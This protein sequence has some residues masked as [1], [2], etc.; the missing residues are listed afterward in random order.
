M[1]YFVSTHYYM[2]LRLQN[3][4]V[5]SA[6]ST[7]PYYLNYHTRTISMAKCHAG[8]TFMMRK[9]IDVL[10]AVKDGPRLLARLFHNCRGT[11]TNLQ[12][13]VTATHAVTSGANLM[14]L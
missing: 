14:N 6:A 7:R 3:N 4:G 8:H 10:E 1:A 12:D 5:L 11:A 13:T 2:L 9:E